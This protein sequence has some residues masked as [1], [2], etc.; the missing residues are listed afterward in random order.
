MR[1]RKI[2]QK[3]FK[4]SFH[5]IFK[6]F[7]GK[8]NISRDLKTIN[9]EKIEV[10]NLKIDK[11]NFNLN[12]NIY[13]IP[14]GRIF[15]DLNEH[16]AVIKDNLIIPEISF[17]QI[18]NELK[19]VEH[20]RVIQKGT[21]RLQKKFDGRVF[22]LV[23]GGS[24]NNYFHFLFDIVT[25]LKIYEE[26]FSLSD[27]DYFYVPGINSWQKQILSL[28]KIDE[29]KLIDSNK[30]RHIK[31]RE[32]IAID[33]PWYKSGYIQKEIKKLP[34]WSILFLREKFLDLRKKFQTSKKI[35]I[36]RTD[37]LYKHCKLINNQ[38]VIEFLEKKGFKSYQTSKLDFYE[39]IYLFENAEIIISPH[40]AALT[41][42]IFSKPGMRLFELIPK[43]HGSVKCERISSFL[44]F[45]YT[46]VDLDPLVT[47][48]NEGDIKIELDQ[49]ERILK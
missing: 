27:I 38:E 42:I 23:Q 45:N 36:D 49:L 2:L 30:Y 43:N 17:Q 35:F 7:Y 18:K 14:E 33:H 1:I 9:F 46:R 22:S 28:F 25:K 39:Q 44:K 31:A 47:D 32:I 34:E 40:G 20:N 29:K 5:L 21:N 24:G 3:I 11:K 48:N 13:I 19:N 15:T 41:N 10:K 37:S 8:I 16:V 6:V 4:K 26:R 12:N